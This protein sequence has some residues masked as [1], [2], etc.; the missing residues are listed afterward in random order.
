MCYF[1][2]YLGAN[3]ETQLNFEKTIGHC[4]A[5]SGEHLNV[6][7]AG[8]YDLL[9]PKQ[10]QLMKFARS[11]LPGKTVSLQVMHAPKIPTIISLGTAAF[12][13]RYRVDVFLW[14]VS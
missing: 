12:V 1:A 8:F 7:V 10:E 3:P 9:K 4:G 13:T 6:S 2:S 14:Q 11:T 5:K